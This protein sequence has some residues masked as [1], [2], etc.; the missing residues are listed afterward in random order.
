MDE[1]DLEEEGQNG[2]RKEWGLERKVFFWNYFPVWQIKHYYISR[3]LDLD[4]K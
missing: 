3:L 2:K 4:S 1:R